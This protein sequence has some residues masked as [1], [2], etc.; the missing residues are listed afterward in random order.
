MPPSPTARAP[1]GKKG[2]G[3]A[4]LVTRPVQTQRPGSPD[5]PTGGSGV[6]QLLRLCL[7]CCSPC[8]WLKPVGSG[9]NWS[10]LQAVLPFWGRRGL[11]LRATWDT[12]PGAASQRRPQSPASSAWKTAARC[13][14]QIQIP[15]GGDIRQYRLARR[16]AQ[17]SRTSPSWPTSR[18]SGRSA[19]PSTTPEDL[20]LVR[21]R[22][23]YPD[24][25][26]TGALDD[27]PADLSRRLFETL[28]TTPQVV[29]SPVAWT[30]T[31]ASTLSI[32]NRGIAAPSRRSRP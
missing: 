29:A 12:A 19:R 3:S 21:L 17:R 6:A 2:H 26:S 15:P 20:T 11:R 32:C 27:M 18:R 10:R 9:P 13:S 4:L 31:C 23:R 7:R 22:M 5:R 14:E 1:P 28:A 8:C 30:R 16:G 25:A 24:Q